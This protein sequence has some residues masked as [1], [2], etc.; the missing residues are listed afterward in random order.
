MNT[1]YFNVIDGPKLFDPHGLELPDKQ[2]AMRHVRGTC[3]RF[4]VGGCV[5]EADCAVPRPF[6]QLETLAVEQP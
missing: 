2:A 6:A 5:T 3:Q 1:Y 4:P